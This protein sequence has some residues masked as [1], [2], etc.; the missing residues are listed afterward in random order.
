MASIATPVELSTAYLVDVKPFVSGNGTFTIRVSGN[1][2]DGAR[3]YS[4][5]GNDPSARAGVGDRL[6]RG[7][8]SPERPGQPTVTGVTSTTAS[9]SWPAST[10]NVGVTGYQ[11][12]RDGSSVGTTNGTTTTFQ[13]TGL[14]PGTAYSYTVTAS[15]AANNQSLPSPP[16][17]ATTPTI[18]GP[19]TSVTASGGHSQA[20]VSW[21][22]PASDGGSPITGYFV[23]PYIGGAAQPARRFGDFDRN[24]GSRHRPGEWHHVHV[25][26]G[27]DQ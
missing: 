24:S 14:S 12:F 3:Y 15:D 5:N 25:P 20:T 26:G 18:P 8:D 22:A 1:S 17:T 6:W 13:D 2:A 9:L 11:I 10:D 27:G 4:R 19:P 21:T 7:H 23:I 16:A